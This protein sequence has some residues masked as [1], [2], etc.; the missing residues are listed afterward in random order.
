[1]YFHMIS[2]FFIRSIY[3]F[4]FILQLILVFVLPDSFSLFWCYLYEIQLHFS[5]TLKLPAYFMWS[6]GKTWVNIHPAISEA[7][8]DQWAEN[9]SV[10]RKMA[11]PRGEK[12]VGQKHQRGEKSQQSM[13]LWFA[14]YSRCTLECYNR[15]NVNWRKAGGLYMVFNRRQMTAQIYYY[16]INMGKANNMETVNVNLVWRTHQLGINLWRFLGWVWI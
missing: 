3:L 11:W 1:M 2:F 12:S 13:N 5:C 6:L 8:T 16:V 10:E 15:R 4:I 7:G 9:L 14:T